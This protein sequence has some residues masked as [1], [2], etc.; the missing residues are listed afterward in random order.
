[1]NL[2]L[3]LILL[4]ICFFLSDGCHLAHCNSS[5]ANTA[6]SGQFQ[7]LDVPGGL[8]F[9]NLPER[10]SAIFRATA[11]EYEN[12]EYLCFVEEI[13]DE[14]IESDSSFNKYQPD[15][16]FTAYYNNTLC[17]VCSYLNSPCAANDLLGY[18]ST[19]RYIFFRVIRI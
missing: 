7:D 9:T 11:A 10:G 13:V 1:M 16:Y 5:K 3:R 14:R 4:S 8:S 17:D 15:N 19:A 2:F 6:A 18:S 12:A